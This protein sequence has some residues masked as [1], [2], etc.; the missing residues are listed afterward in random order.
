M[1]VTDP[2]NYDD[3]SIDD[4][5]QAVTFSEST[6]IDDILANN[7][8]LVVGNEGVLDM[9]IPRFNA[10]G[11]DMR[12]LLLD[13][14]NVKE[15][16]SPG[17]F[18]SFSQMA[19][20]HNPHELVRKWYLPNKKRLPGV[21][22]V[23]PR[24]AAL[25]R[26]RMFSIV[27]TTG[28]DDLLEQLMGSVWDNLRVVDMS[29]RVSLT[30][31]SDALQASIHGNE[32]T[33]DEPTLF[34]IFGK[35]KNEVANQF[36]LTDNDA[37]RIIHRWMDSET[38]NDNFFYFITKKKILSLGCNFD[39]WHMRF[40][41]YILRR[42]IDNISKGQIVNR[43][44]GDKESQLVSYLEQ[45]KI[46]HEADTDGFI[47]RILGLLE[48]KADNV[49]LKDRID[50]M[51]RRGGIFLSY[52][53]QNF[54]L[55]SNLFM[56]LSQA[57]YKVWFDNV[58]LYGGANYDERIAE[59]IAECKVFIP[60]LTPTSAALLKENDVE[61]TKPED[62]PYVM[63]EWLLASHTSKAEIIPVAHLGFSQRGGLYK[64][65][66][67]EKIVGRTCTCI[68]MLE[69]DGFDKLK[70]SIDRVLCY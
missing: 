31:F 11:G 64:E 35:A 60:L 5:G 33:Y 61:T 7:Y 2:F 28:F 47:D 14:V 70:A 38:L 45:N 12:R 50:S 52:S 46:Y 4:N 65:V 57:G 24:L 66:F 49:R 30:D 58:E 27:F 54:H 41:W 36:V 44:V 53:S 39:D 8:I 48:M 40:F 67:E 20:E 6:F 59:A 1:A 9:S 56:R 17:R 34:Y 23:S 25:I 13:L 26:S 51:R 18:N 3:F 19:K 37:I 21:E 16:N 55:A 68:N 63:R 15:F 42:N 43:G 62:L 32:I 69:I 22:H 10:I 29:D